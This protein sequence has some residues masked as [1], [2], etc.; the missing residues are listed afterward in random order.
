LTVAIF[1]YLFSNTML[2]NILAASLHIGGRSSI[3]NLRK[4]HVVVTGTHTSVIYY[5]MFTNV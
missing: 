3:R 2:F 5:K 1:F 4:R